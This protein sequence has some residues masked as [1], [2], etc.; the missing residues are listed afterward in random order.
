MSDLKKLIY[1]SFFLF[2]ATTASAQSS[3][4][5]SNNKPTVHYIGNL[6][7]SISH[8]P[9]DLEKLNKSQLCNVYNRRAL[10]L[11]EL[12]P[13]MALKIPIGYDA[14]KLEVPPMTKSRFKAAKKQEALKKKYLKSISNTMLVINP[15]ADKADLI[16][17]IIKI[18]LW[19]VKINDFI[20]LEN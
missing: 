16:D 15:N 18:D 11:L 7:L 4:K 6:S 2:L 13:Y 19:I 10:I 8:N 12:L 5:N 20:N 17:I 14:E 1:F 3:K 9:H